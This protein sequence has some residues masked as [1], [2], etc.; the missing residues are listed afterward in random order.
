MSTEVVYPAARKDIAEGPSAA[1]ADAS[2]FF[3]DKDYYFASFWAV[4]QINSGVTLP[5]KAAILSPDLHQMAKLVLLVS[6]PR[7]SAVARQSF[8]LAQNLDA[9]P[10]PAQP[11]RLRS[12]SHVDY[13]LMTTR[14]VS[15]E[16]SKELR[17]WQPSGR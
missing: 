3:G 7:G 13:I 4:W 8:T 2:K 1:R 10:L 15:A 16:I 12:T 14:A 5:P 6:I 17:M 11:G 9:S